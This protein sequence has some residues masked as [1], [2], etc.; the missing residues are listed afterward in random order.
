VVN[1]DPEV[2][3]RGKVQNVF[4]YPTPSS[5]LRFNHPALSEVIIMMMMTMMTIIIIIIKTNI[6]LITYNHY[7]QKKQIKSKTFTFCM[8]LI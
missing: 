8:L 6:L 5:I 4:F 3:C 1:A 7:L 2:T